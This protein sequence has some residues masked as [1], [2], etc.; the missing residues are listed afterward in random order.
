MKPV[1]KAKFHIGDFGSI[2]SVTASDYAQTSAFQGGDYEGSPI[3]VEKQTGINSYIL[4]FS[5]LNSG[6]VYKD[7]YNGLISGE[8]YFSGDWYSSKYDDYPTLQNY[9]ITINGSG[10]KCI[11]INFDKYAGVYATR[12]GIPFSIDGFMYKT[13]DSYSFTLFLPENSSYE[14]LPLE[15]QALNKPNVP[16]MITSI[17]VK[18]DVT[19]TS[20][21]TLYEVKRG[22]QSTN[23][24]E[25]PSYGI[26]TQYG[27]VSFVD[28]EDMYFKKLAELDLLHDIGLELFINDNK[29]GTYL[30]S[31]DWNYNVYNNKI[32]VE[33]GSKNL[34]KLQNK[35]IETMVFPRDITALSFLNNIISK[36]TDEKLVFD[37]SG[38]EDYLKKI[39]IG[40]PYFK[41]GSLW[42]QLNKFCNMAQLRMYDTPDGT[43]VV[44]RFE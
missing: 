33:I 39:K 16:V 2:T 3:S 37:L 4:D 8:A 20:Q 13:N 42:E 35:N 19:I 34:V 17:V 21:D 31:D 6:A 27:N 18:N 43:I 11:T 12:I 5:E 40:F 22:S 25:R 32:D 24:F 41:S 29:I 36:F 1:V 14:N 30:A 28:T 26:A 44:K 38:V 7:T 15:I 23:D 9:K 10:I